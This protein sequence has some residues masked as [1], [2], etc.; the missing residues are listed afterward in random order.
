MQLP[1][2][3]AAQLVGYVLVMCRVGGLFVLAPIFS[4]RMI[5]AQAKVIVA[6]AISFALEPMVVANQT[7]PTGVQVVPLIM[8]ELLVGL[9][10]ALVLGVVAAGV[11]AAASIMDTMVGFSFAQLVDPLTQG[12]SAVIGQLYSLFTVVIFLLIGGDHLMIEGLDASYRLIPLGSVPSATQ[13]GAIAAND[14]SQMFLIAIEVAAPVIVA[15]AM[16]D[17]AL[18]LVARSVP[19]MNVFIVGIPAKIM[20]GLGAIAASLPFLTGHLE[21]Q[22]TN[23]VY[24]ALQSLRVH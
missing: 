18:A 1:G 10:F 6:G 23:A 19:Q 11:Q 24:T 8:K 13:L 3:A 22:L 20:V 5:P 2:I 17:I 21:D 16:V 4:G 15:L 12:Q 9:A 7:I 14:L